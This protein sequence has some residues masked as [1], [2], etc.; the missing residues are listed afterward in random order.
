MPSCFHDFGQR[1]ATG[2]SVTNERVAAVV[3]CEI[4]EAN[5]AK[6]ATCGPEALTQD[7]AAEPIVG[8]TLLPSYLELL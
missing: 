8:S 5:C 4:G 3:D 6:A 2:E 1:A 7:V